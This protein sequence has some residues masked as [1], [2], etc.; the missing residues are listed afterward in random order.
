MMFAVIVITAF[1][2]LFLGIGLLVRSQVNITKHSYFQKLQVSVFLCPEGSPHAQCPAKA[3]SGQIDAVQAQ[4]D[5]LRPLVTSVEFIDQQRA[6]SIY[7]DLFKDAPDLVNN[8]DPSALPE[9]F[10]VKLSDPKKFDVV[11]TAVS[12]MAGVDVVQNEDDFL[13]KLFGVMNAVRNGVLV[14]CGVLIVAA[15]VLIG[16]AVQVAAV[17]RRRETGI[18]RL[19]GASSLYI[20]LPFLLEGVL[21]GIIGALFGFGGVSAA[22]YFLVDGR[23]KPILPVLG[24]RLISWSDVFATLPWLIGLS[25]VV[26]ALA[27]FLTLRRYLKV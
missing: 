22:K 16:V 12:G 9:S 17:S 3:N 26:A 18:M 7:K 13:K 8:T 6:W 20:Q 25:A 2:M 15:G 10:V 23:L 11:S 21:A 1:S 14:A 27:S 19:V 4:L 24:G 5:N